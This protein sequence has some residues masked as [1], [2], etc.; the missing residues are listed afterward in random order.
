MEE[1]KKLIDECVIMKIKP[2]SNTIPLKEVNYTDEF[3]P[4]ENYQ[5]DID[6]IGYI[7]NSFKTNPKKNYSDI[8]QMGISGDLMKESEFYSNN[9]SINSDQTPTQNHPFNFQQ[10]STSL[11]FSKQH[12]PKISKFKKTALATKLFDERNSSDNDS[13]GEEFN[14][15]SNTQIP[16]FIQP[17]KSKTSSRSNS[18]KSES[19]I[20]RF[21]FDYK[22]NTITNDSS[23][24]IKFSINSMEKKE[25]KFNGIE[26]RKKKVDKL[27][28]NVKESWQG[29][30]S[31]M[32]F[33]DKNED[34]I[35]RFTSTEEIA[36]FNEYNKECLELIK[37]IDKNSKED[38]SQYEVDYKLDKDKYKKL[39]I[40]DLDETLIHCEYSDVFLAEHTLDVLI[41][42]GKTTKVGINIRPFAYECLKKLKEESKYDIV[43]Y[44]ASI[45][46]YANA[47]L[48]IIDKNNDIFSYRVFRDNCIKSVLDSNIVYIK[49]LRIFKHVDIKDMLIV[50]NSL[51]S[52]AF[53]IDSGIP[54]LPFYSNKN[55]RELVYL[56]QYLDSIVNFYD[57]STENKKF[58][59]YDRSPS[60]YSS[61][62]LEQSLDFRDIRDIF[63]SKNSLEGS[64]T[65]NLIHSF[66]VL[67]EEKN[68]FSNYSLKNIFK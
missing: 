52:F 39:I 50:D 26:P 6:N 41:Q 7:N 35:T 20:L 23:Y 46:Q 32:S 42:S 24:A 63:S 14:F 10:N 56:V 49:D 36:D 27:I 60:A 11:M 68:K 57:L 8:K 34:D 12:T 40:F 22:D 15:K 37:K 21:D 65:S 25:L 64:L 43:C 16:N 48:D 13:D 59:K 28:F 62:I 67:N 2:Y 33:E 19:E 53:N 18:S 31:H 45:S 1:F 17:Q 66:D 44:T 54:I 4:K 61:I 29:S 51:L 38:V 9:N 30:Y 55:D 47:V 5:Y 3:M 58:I